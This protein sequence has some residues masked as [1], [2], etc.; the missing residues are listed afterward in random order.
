V[1]GGNKQ[2][3]LIK[4]A[5]VRFAQELRELCETLDGLFTEA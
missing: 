5:G 1:R 3:A 4:V 2:P